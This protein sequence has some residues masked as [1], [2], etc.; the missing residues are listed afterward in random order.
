MTFQTTSRVLVAIVVLVLVVGCTYPT[1]SHHEVHFDGSVERVNGSF[2][3]QGQVDIS[4]GAAPTRTFT[5]VRVILYGQNE[6][7]VEQMPL[8]TMS[9]NASIAPRQRQVNITADR[10]PK[11]VLIES[12]DFWDGNLPVVAYRWTGERYKTYF[13]NE[14]DERFPAT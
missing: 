4:V 7:I 5:D 13:V 11:Y 9:T 12:P 1:Q 10:L 14:P 8:G 6:T 3:M 2:Q